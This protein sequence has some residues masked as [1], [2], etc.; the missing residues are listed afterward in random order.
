MVVYNTESIF[1]MPNTSLNEEWYKLWRVSTYVFIDFDKAILK[2]L[3]TISQTFYLCMVYVG[4]IENQFI[5][6]RKIGRTVRQFSVFSPDLFNLHSK[7]I[8]KVL[9]I[10]LLWITVGHYL[11]KQIYAGVI[12]L[13][14]DRGWK[15]Q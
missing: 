12:V 6:Y 13:K 14:A 9:E 2:I 10:L 5:K 8:L 7:S 1:T 4:Q 3:L 15:L 11:N